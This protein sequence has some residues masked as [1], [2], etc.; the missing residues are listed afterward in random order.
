MS[1][2]CGN[3]ER[4]IKKE[5][6][7]ATPNG[8]NP[9]LLIAQESALEVGNCQQIIEGSLSMSNSERYNRN[10]TMPQKTDQTKDRL[11]ASSG[12]GLPMLV[13]HGRCRR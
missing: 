8:A 9:P 6:F 1:G 5:K 3:V 11:V 2:N 7:L 12:G 10:T 13:I 4:T